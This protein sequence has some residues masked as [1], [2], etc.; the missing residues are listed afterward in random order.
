MS[1]A[2]LGLTVIFDNCPLPW[3]LGAGGAPPSSG[4]MSAGRLWDAPRPIFIDFLP[5]Q[6]RIQK[7]FYL[8][9]VM[10]CVVANLDSI[11]VEFPDT[12]TH[13]CL[14]SSVSGKKFLYVRE[15]R[16][17]GGQFSQMGFHLLC[18]TPLHSVQLF[19]L[20]I[21]IDD[22]WEGTHPV[23]LFETIPFLARRAAVDHDR[24][25]RLCGLHHLGVGERTCVQPEVMLSPIRRDVNDDRLSRSFCIP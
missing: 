10:G 21:E 4:S 25:K 17:G 18:L 6:G 5:P 19:G 1:V 23:M 8:P 16:K 13:P 14:K 11:R 3:D 20:G 22:R 9:Q 24:D 15:R 2:A 12:F 7:S